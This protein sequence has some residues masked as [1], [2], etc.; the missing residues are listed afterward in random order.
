MA[1]VDPVLLDR[2]QFGFTIA[3][4]IIFPAMS[5]G[6]GSY[7]AVLEALWLATGQ[8]RYLQL[9]RYWMKAF[10]MSF[11][12]GV[13]SGLVMAYEF[14]TNWSVLSDKAGPIIGPL[15]SYET[16]TAFFLEAGFLGVM[17]FGFNRVPRLVHFGATLLVALG[18]LISA[19]W[20]LAANSWMQTPAGYA[21]NAAGQFVPVDWFKVV[22][23]PS[24]PYRLVHMTLAAYLATAFMVGGVGALHLL[25]GERGIEVRTMFSMAMWMAAIVAPIQI[26]AGDQQG[27]NT[28]AYQPAKI[29]AMEGDFGAN[30]RGAPLILFGW[31]DLPDD[32]TLDAVEI[33]HLGSLILT[34]SYD[35]T[36][37]GLDHFPRADWPDSTVIFWT[38][39]AMVGLGF[40]M[41]FLGLSSLALRWRKRLYDTSWF[42]AWALVMGPAGF[43]AIVCGWV[44]TEMGRQPYTVYGLL[45]TAK[46][47]SPVASPAVIASLVAII[48]VYV[49][50]FGAG[51]W[52]LLRLFST[53]PEEAQSDRAEEGPTRAAGITP[54]FALRDAQD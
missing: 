46:S 11:G 26:E 4:H 48:L 16:M 50:V 2:I 38:F 43:V 42:T 6:L 19:F 23:N 41:F 8:E 34:H 7:L 53:P 21:I 9:F 45:R 51:V 25:R 52:Y 1:H 17:L 20:I 37:H 31:P 22:F 15:M 24:F 33:P 30:L 27:L 5:I 29:A 39:R 14:G 54:A 12:M 35:G 28:L 13:V 10:A 44:T 32:E 49:T 3:L 40:L 18:A 36:V 47:A